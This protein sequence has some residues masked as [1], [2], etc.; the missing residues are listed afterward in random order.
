M[1]SVTNLK[2]IK[3]TVASHLEAGNLELVVL[4][5]IEYETLLSKFEDLKDLHDS[6]KALKEYQSGKYISF[7][8]YDACRKAQRVSG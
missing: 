2:K 5:R 7:N 8:R 3:K 1:V 4:P 6:I